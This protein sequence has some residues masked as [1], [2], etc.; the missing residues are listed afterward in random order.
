MILQGDRDA[1]Q[2]QKAVDA[3]GLEGAMIR[4]DLLLD[5]VEQRLVQAWQRLKPQPLDQGDRIR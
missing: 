5:Q 2:H 3:H 4:Q 1:K